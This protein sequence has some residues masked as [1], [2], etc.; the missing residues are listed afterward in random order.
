MTCPLCQGT[1][2]VE[3]GLE[4]Q[5]C[6]QCPPKL[7]NTK[8]IGPGDDD[9]GRQKPVPVCGMPADV[10]AKVEADMAEVLALRL[11][12]AIDA[13]LKEFQRLRAN[14]FRCPCGFDT[15]EFAICEVA[16]VH[17]CPSCRKVHL[18]GP[19]S[20]VMDLVNNHWKVTQERNEADRRAGAA[21][22]HMAS[23]KDDSFKREQ[24]LDKAKR[25]AGYDRSVSFDVVWAAALKALLKIDSRAQKLADARDALKIADEALDK[26]GH[27]E[28]SP[29][30][31]AIATALGKKLPETPDIVEP[32]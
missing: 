25:E 7:D 23:L 10:L 21:E 6:H 30:R 11:A 2:W 4:R 15:I 12:D 17:L 5:P 9:Y 22:R 27:A 1:G 14:P 29:P 18:I 32:A 3:R 31:V 19:E 8:L 26:E 13:E 28:C 20:D 16:S 24:W